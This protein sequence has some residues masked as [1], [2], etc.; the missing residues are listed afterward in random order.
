MKLKPKAEREEKTVSRVK[1]FPLKGYRELLKG[2][3]F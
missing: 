1:K 3:L 2:F